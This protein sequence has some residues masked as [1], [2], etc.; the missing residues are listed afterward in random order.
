MNLPGGNTIA[1]VT[2]YG[3]D[4]NPPP[5]KLGIDPG[6]ALVLKFINTPLAA[7]TGASGS[8]IGLHV[9]QIG[10]CFA[11]SAT[12]INTTVVPEP[13]TLSLVALSGLAL[14]RRRRS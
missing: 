1:F 10:D 7:F 6:E 8:R 14:F 9:Q 2:D 5:T 4:A 13:A 3:Y 11:D 12:F